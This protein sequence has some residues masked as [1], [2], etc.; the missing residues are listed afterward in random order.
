MALSMPTFTDGTSIDAL[1][2]R[3]RASD[4]ETFL[5]RQIVSGDLK[6]SSKWVSR[7]QIYKPEFYGSPSP[8]MEAVSGDTYYRFADDVAQE[9]AVFH[10]DQV[11]NTWIPVPGL[12]ATI[13]NPWK[14]SVKCTV[15]ASF[16]AMTVEGITLANPYTTRSAQFALYLNSTQQTGTVRELYAVHS[17]GT[18]ANLMLG[19]ENI[20]IVGRPTV[21]TGTHDISVKIRLDPTTFG[22]A[23]SDEPLWK[24]TL[25][26]PR[27][28]VIDFHALA[29]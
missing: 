15:S 11:V 18:F 27:T 5:N 28:L 4:V 8:R 22:G 29:T 16:Y 10:G 14:T 21:S 12:S 2:L 13:R 25:V 6:T 1:D 9:A 24:H 3:A 7:I 26:V 20:S 17:V 19:R 23:G